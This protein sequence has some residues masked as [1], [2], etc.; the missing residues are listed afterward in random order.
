MCASIDSCDYPASLRSRD[1]QLELPQPKLNVCIMI[2]GTHGDV[3]PFIS[4]AKALRAQNGHR[5]RIATHAMHRQLVE[6]EGIEFFPLA[7]DPKKLSSFMVETKGTIWGE[8][9]HPSNFPEKSKMVKAI[10]ESCWPAVTQPDPEGGEP[11]RA[12]AIISNPP[13]GGHLHVAEALGVPLHLM[14]PQ[15]AY[16]GTKEF[17]HP[18]AGLKVLAN[19]P[20]NRQS[21]TA[22]EVLYLT[23]FGSHINRWRSKTLGL[24]RLYLGGLLS[25]GK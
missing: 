12:D 11:F 3:L 22:F 21:Y 6:R 16:F 24:H 14:F 2:C 7:G 10:I 23:A 1:D 9:M 4:L 8:A 13:T 5:V 18:M 20:G 17:P 15:P 25:R 19:N